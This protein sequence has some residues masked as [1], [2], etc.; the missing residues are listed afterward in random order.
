MHWVDTTEPIRVLKEKMYQWTG[1]PLRHQ[2]LVFEGRPLED[3][4]TLSDYR[5]YRECIIGVLRVR[6]EEAPYRPRR[7]RV[8]NALELDHYGYL[9][10]KTVRGFRAEDEPPAEVYGP[11][12]LTDS[13]N[14]ILV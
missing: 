13:D 8:M 9:F 5:V 11:W 2:K 10:G 12:S 14:R 4:K 6:D 7:D 3:H 1:I